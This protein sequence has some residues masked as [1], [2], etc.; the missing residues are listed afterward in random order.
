MRTNQRAKG[1]MFQAEGTAWVKAVKWEIVW[2]L[3]VT[4][5]RLKWSEGTE[6]GV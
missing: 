5:R 6:G 4:K 2:H 3:Q 1:R